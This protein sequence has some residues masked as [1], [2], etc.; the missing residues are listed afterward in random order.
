MEVELA[1]PLTKKPR[2]LYSDMEEAKKEVGSTK[3]AEEE[4]EEGG[5]LRQKIQRKRMR[6]GNLKKRMGPSY[7][8]NVD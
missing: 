5:D 3:E 7:S 8:Q 4:K 1:L 6:R 2:T